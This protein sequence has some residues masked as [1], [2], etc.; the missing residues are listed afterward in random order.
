[1]TTLII[2]YVTYRNDNHASS[3]SSVVEPNLTIA[4]QI[5]ANN[6]EVGGLERGDWLAIMQAMAAALPCATASQLGYHGRIGK[7]VVAR[8]SNA[9]RFGDVRRRGGSWLAV[10][11][12]QPDVEKEAR[13]EV[14]G[15]DMPTRGG[16]RVETRPAEEDRRVERMFSNLNEVS[17]K[18]EP[19]NLVSAVLLIAGT[20]VG[21]GILAIPSVTQESGF[22]AS[23][24][25]C[26][27]CWLYM[28]RRECSPSPLQ[29]WNAMN[30]CLL[31]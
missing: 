14:S 23:S 5:R 2:H 22:L 30:S 4:E 15:F 28:V 24:V 6:L 27:G 18:H 20:T 17:L 13:E 9:R 31:D 21:A 10:R 7:D 29:H 25:A 3:F 26:I 12:K 8:R 11:S 1:V 19:G 16:A